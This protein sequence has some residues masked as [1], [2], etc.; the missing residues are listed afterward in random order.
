MQKRSGQLVFS[1]TDIC[2][3]Y[4]SPFASWMDRSRL[5]RP[6]TEAPQGD[7]PQQKLLAAMGMKH[8]RHHV[9]TVRAKGRSVWEP[10]SGLESFDEKH[11]ATLG[12]MSAGH[13]VIYQGALRRGAFEGYADFLYRVETP[14]RLG[15]WSYEVADTKLARL[16]NP[17]FLLQLCAYAKML[18]HLQGLRPERVFIVDGASNEI[19]FRTD[20]YFYYFTALERRFLEGQRAFD[21]NARPVPEA[22]ADHGRWQGRADAILDEMDHPC[23]VAGITVHQINRLREG[24][25]TTLTDLASTTIERIP[26]LEPATFGRL[27]AQ[28]RLQLGSR[29][30]PRPLYE[31]VVPDADVAR[32]GFAL[33]PPLSAMDVY[34]DM[35]GYP[36]AEGGLEYLFGATVVEKGALS[37]KDF[38]GHDRAGEKRAFEGFVD[39]AYDRYLADPSMHIYHYASYEVAA[40]R[41]LMGGHGTRE[42]AIDTLLRA[43]VFVDLYRIVMQA[44]RIGEPRYSLKNVERLYRPA[45]ASD[46]AT[47]AQSVVEYARWLEER[48]GDGWET[49][50]ILA[51]I[52]E[53]NRDDCESTWRLHG[54]LRERQVEAGIAYVP[55]PRKEK[56]AD[57]EP[58]PA[59]TAADALAERLLGAIPHDRSVEPE[60]WRL[61][62]LLAHLVGFHLREAKPVWW[63]LFDREEKTHGELVE[64]A[65]CLG[66]LERT[67]T[68][69]I[70]FKQSF[71]YEYRFN[72][73]QD[74]KLSEGSECYIA[75]RTE[76]RVQT[77]IVRLD[78]EAGLLQVKLGKKTPEPPHLLSLLPREHVDA[79][80]IASSIAAVA[81]LWENT[82]ELPLRSTPS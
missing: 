29:N 12:A 43:E 33:L 62:E 16:P 82:G 9:A 53:Y 68:P 59:R 21:P 31:L 8:E 22:R 34:F 80:S 78:A 63:A 47:A 71:L 58:D 10:P 45:R 67:S 18:E 26:K 51:G 36:F 64:D 72:P 35:E 20:D 74:T 54:W 52:R 61:Q 66:A 77:T 28:A 32:Y 14:S 11:E 23:R 70:P 42:E 19:S 15:G 2:R 48:D 75:P 27:R 73:N 81:R 24:G 76:E 55:P 37:F 44:V 38:W 46:V 30:R 65:D 56:R 7:P 40:L 17:Y 41:R 3:F 39:W 25:V 1:P 13:Q 6:G 49:S 79:R 69:K 57:E 50:A 5:E 4:E 60:R